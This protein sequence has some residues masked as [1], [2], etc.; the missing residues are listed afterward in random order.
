M[1]GMT[2][3]STDHTKGRTDV[4]ENLPKRETF[5]RR[6]IL[7][8]RSDKLYLRGFSVKRSSASDR[9][10]YSDEFGLSSVSSAMT[11][12]PLSEMSFGVQKSLTVSVTL[13]MCCTVRLLSSANSCRDLFLWNAN[14]RA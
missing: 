3:F 14:S 10:L 8:R 6:I 1:Q 13:Q 5:A 2:G 12:A 9:S 11:P 4:D 7:T